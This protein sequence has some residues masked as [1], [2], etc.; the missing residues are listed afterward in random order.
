[1]QDS[2][3]NTL[4]VPFGTADAG[5]PNWEPAL[6]VKAGKKPLRVMC[7]NISE[8]VDFILAFDAS[9]LKNLPGV[10]GTYTLPAGDS[11][12]FVLAPEQSLYA[13]ANGTDGKICVAY[14]E[15]LPFDMKP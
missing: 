2:K 15:A 8:A 3:F 1:M 13:I 12:V 9:S 6:I 4:A 7:R 11:D 5:A 14:S 10:G